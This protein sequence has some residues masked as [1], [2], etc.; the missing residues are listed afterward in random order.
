[1]DGENNVLAL[2]QEPSSVFVDS[3]FG[4]INSPRT[5]ATVYDAMAATD[6]FPQPLSVASFA[7]D[8]PEK[9]TLKG[10]LRC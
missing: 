9:E 5:N 8:H 2:Y 7:I 4:E 10:G 3:P 6:Q 1:M